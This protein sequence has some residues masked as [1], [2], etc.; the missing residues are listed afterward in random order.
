MV[1]IIP[2]AGAGTKLRPHTYTQPKSLIPIAGKP[3]I[4]YI[5]DQLLD[6]GVEKFVFVIGYLGDKIREYI[7]ES[8]PHIKKHYVIQQMREGLGHAVWLTKDVI[9][10]KE[11]VIIILG[12][13]I[14]DVD[15]KKI[16]KS[17]QSVIGVKKVEDPRLFGVAEFGNDNIIT[18]LSEKPRIPMSNMAMVGL[19]MVKNFGKL[20]QAIDYNISNNIR[21]HNEFFLTDGLQKMIEEG[22]TIIA[23]KIDHWYDC[24]QKNILLKTNKIMLQ[25]LKNNYSNHEGLNNT[26]VIEPVHIGKNT[27]IRNSIIGPNVTIGDNAVVEYTI[28][29]DCIIGNF[30][31]LQDVVLD[32]SLIGSDSEIYGSTQSLSI[33]DNT[34]LDLR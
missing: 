32:N 23:E 19:Y 8:F 5:I 9:K 14:M 28:L 11:K 21:T 24:G 27:I 17:S 1:A 6:A 34:E 13:T 31:R 4:G 25:R 7:D 18:R 2:V 16:I 12:D 15:L 26:I 22:E 29:R 20:Y 33:G 10:P 30:T 3:L